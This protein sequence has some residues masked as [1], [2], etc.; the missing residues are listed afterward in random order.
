[1]VSRSDIGPRLV[2]GKLIELTVAEKDKL[3]A[4]RNAELVIIPV[5][6]IELTLKD[7]IEILEA[8]VNITASDYAQKRQD[9]R[10][11]GEA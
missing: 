11:K 3:V 1:M 5:S 2:N 7:R 9:K 4:E 6:E 10:D 8:K